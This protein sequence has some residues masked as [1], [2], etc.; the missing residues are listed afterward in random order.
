MVPALFLFASVVNDVRTLVAAHDFAA[1]DREVRD[2]QA[3]QGATPELAAALSWLA[4]GSL[5]AKQFDS[6][7]SYAAETRT[8]ADQLLRSRKLD[9]DSWLPTALG[10]SM[11]V[12]A[13]VLAARGERPEALE[14]LRLQLKLFSGTSL[15]ERIRK[16]VNLLTLEGKT[17]PP[18]EVADWVG[19]RPVPLA[20]LHGRPVLLFFWAHW[21]GDCKAEAASLARIRK[22]FEPQGLVI[23]APTRYYGYVAKGADATPEVEK[24][25]IDQVRRQYYSELAGVAAPL[26]AANFVAYGSS[27][28]PTLVLID[29]A[30]IVRMYHPGALSESDLSARIQTILKK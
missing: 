8:L 21:C 22:T 4:R 23:V 19:A 27:T 2:Y 14:F 18:L 30:G 9:A 5:E 24:N 15:T 25:Y 3:R 1:A 29:A 20:S 10:A 12:H 26:S 17:A 6:A 7:D 28:T 13:Q 16:N 11:E